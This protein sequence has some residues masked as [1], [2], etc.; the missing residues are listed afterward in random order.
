[1]VIDNKNSAIAVINMK[2]LNIMSLSFVSVTG[3]NYRAGAMHIFYEEGSNIMK[4]PIAFI[5]SQI[6]LNK[7]TEQFLKKMKLPL[8]RELLV[9]KKEKKSSKIE[10]S[11]DEK[12]LYICEG[13]KMYQY[14]LKNGDK[15]K[16]I[17]EGHKND[18]KSFT[19][20]NRKNYIY[21]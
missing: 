2:T 19:I 15:K 5:R 21:R 13:Q 9:W 18:I 3:H 8:P 7:L 1:L 11:Q 4:V 20:D 14:S 17:F 12:M 6:P 16:S 10:L